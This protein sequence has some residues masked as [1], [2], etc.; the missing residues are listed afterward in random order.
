MN[1]FLDF[2]IVGV[3]YGAI[4]AIVATGLVVT[5]TTSG[6]FNFAHGAIGMLM[7]FSYWE[8]RVH[9]H[10]PA[11]IALVLVL[12]V[13]APLFGALIERILMR[14][15]SGASTGASLVV[16][17]GLL[18]VLLY[19][20]PIKWDSSVSRNLPEFFRGHFVKIGGVH[21]SWGQLITIALAGLVAIGLRLLFYRT[22]AG[23]TMRAVVDDRDLTALNGATPARVSQM[24]WALGASLAALAGILIAPTVGL[25]PF[26]LTFLVVNG[27]AAAM[28][29]RLKSLP[30]TFAGAMILGLALEYTLA[31]VPLK[32]WAKNLPAVV[33]TIM[34][35]IVLIALPAVRLRVGRLV[36]GK[37]PKV[38]SSRQALAGSAV[39]IAASV[40]VANLLGGLNLQLASKGLAISILML[41]LV[42]LTG[43]GGQ[44][45]LCQ[46]TFAGIGAYAFGRWAHGG[47]PLMLIPV[48]LVCGVVGAIVALPALRLQGLYLALS[49]LAFAVLADFEFFKIKLSLGSL[50]VHRL[51]I[52]GVSLKDNRATF[53]MLA[54]VFCLFAMLVLAIRRGPFGRLL[55]AMSD[56]PA[57]CATLGLDLTVTKLGV[58]FVSA[59][60][61]G[62]AGALYAGARNVVTT[63]DFQYIQSLIILLLIYVGGINTVTGAFLGGAFIAGSGILTPHLPHSLQQFTGL[64]TGLG[65]ITIGR[66]PNGVAG[67]LSEAWERL[68]GGLIRP[69]A[70]QPRALVPEGGQVAAAN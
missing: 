65:A 34:L 21:V 6:I 36:G 66:N 61:A 2:T 27:Y 19:A 47:D 11:P 57:A 59:A 62:V 56:S 28:V 29:G 24:S 39:F 30:L 48:A 49:T 70:A 54:V 9:Q 3:V 51:A 7:A 15:L 31:Y 43:Y 1:H 55:S 20:V 52:P 13:L 63:I 32:G 8:L 40:L 14:N 38:P 5:Y 68:R 25:E 12:G 42:L 41:S 35:F 46:F 10:L 18:V 16:T 60:M 17:L 64:A 50:T 69:T 67:Q 26:G 23:M 4:Y 37:T 33:P 53:V 22:R 58:F 45:S 44:V